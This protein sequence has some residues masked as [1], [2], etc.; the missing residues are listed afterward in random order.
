MAFPRIQHQAFLFFNI[1]IF[2]SLWF[3]L[4]LFFKS[5]FVDLLLFL[6]ICEC[7]LAHAPAYVSSDNLFSFA[8][9]T[10]E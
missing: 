4:L 7:M 9:V 8:F 5:T 2:L 10:V 3:L 6:Y 1:L